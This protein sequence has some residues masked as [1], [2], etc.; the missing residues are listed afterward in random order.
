ML[1]IISHMHAFVQLVPEVIP[2]QILP[3]K[4]EGNLSIGFIQTHSFI[5]IL[6]PSLWMRIT[7]AHTL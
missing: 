1:L 6:K 5:H 7:P 2:G 3:Q 4:P